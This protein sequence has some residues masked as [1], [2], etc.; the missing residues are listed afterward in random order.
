MWKGDSLPLTSP[1]GFYRFVMIFLKHEILCFFQI[2]L[3]P[4]RDRQC[5][6]VPLILPPLDG[7]APPVINVLPIDRLTVTAEGGGIPSTVE[8]LQAKGKHPPS[9]PCGQLTKGPVYQGKGTKP[10][11]Q[12]SNQSE[13]YVSVYQ[14]PQR[15]S[16]S[17][18]DNDYYY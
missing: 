12:T 6:G 3:L 18:D 9:A 1:W 2:R 7:T 11:N 17:T 14:S 10:E 8:P 5:Y 15:C 13:D 4:L 16:H